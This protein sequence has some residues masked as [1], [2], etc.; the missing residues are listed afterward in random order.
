MR[1]PFLELKVGFEMAICGVYYGKG[2]VKKRLLE[3]S[4]S[5]YEVQAFLEGQAWVEAFEQKVVGH[6]Y[7]EERV[8]WFG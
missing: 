6:V 4:D 7:Y 8:F 2:R 1:A 5:R 3:G